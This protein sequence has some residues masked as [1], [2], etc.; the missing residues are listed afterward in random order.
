MSPIWRSFL[1]GLADV[2]RRDPATSLVLVAAFVV[3]T[4]Y[5][6]GNAI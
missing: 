3:S 5:M 1:G 4:Y 2:L 6:G